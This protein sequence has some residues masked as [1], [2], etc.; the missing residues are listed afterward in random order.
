MPESSSLADALRKHFGFSEFRP[1][2]RELIEAVLAGRDVLGVLPTGGG[3]SLTYQLPALFLPGLTLVVSPLIALM[4]DQVDAFNRRHKAVAVAIHSNQT[5]RESGEAL[6]RV[7]RGAA[8][9]L[10]I[11]PERLELPG[12]R[13]QLA[14]L[15][16]RLLVIDEAHCVSMW[17]HDFRPS[18]LGLG[19]FAARLRP[20]PVLALTATA[21][22]A[23]RTDILARLGLVDPLVQVAPFDRPN[24]RFEVHPCDPGEKPR[25]LRRIIKDLA[26][27]GSQIVY[28]GRRKDAEEIAADLQEAGHRAVAYHAGLAAHERKA[29]QEAWLSG[30]ALIAVATIAFGMGIDKPDVRAVIHYQH[31]SSLESYYQEAGRA[32]RDGLP[33]QCTVLF[34][35]KDSALAQYFIRNRYPSRPQVLSL[36]AALPP[37]GIRP[38]DLKLLG[39]SAMSD[40]QRNVAL[41]TLLQQGLVSRDEAGNF[42]RGAGQPEQVSLRAMAARKDGDYRRLDAMVAYGSEATCHRAVVLRYFGETWPPDYRCRNCSAC[43]GGTADTGQAAAVDEAARIFLLNR[44]ALEAPGPLYKNALASFLGG[45]KSG[46]VPEQWRRLPGFGA[47]AH[48]RGETLRQVADEVLAKEPP[49]PAHPHLHSPAGADSSLPRAGTPVPPLHAA[50]MPAPQL[51]PPGA[52]SGVF[53]RSPKRSFTSQELETREVPRDRG[54]HILRLV[55]ANGGRFAPSMVV[56][57]LR[58]GAQNPDSRTP[59]LKALP[60][61]AVLSALPYG[62]LLPDVLAMWAKGYLCRAGDKGVK[63]CLTEKGKTVIH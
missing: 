2:Q 33:A 40:E 18:Y 54:L 44:E 28:V 14:A 63:L 42:H 8:A 26:G 49:S 16:P 29:A 47:L 55:A 34:S 30:R 22:P 23:T 48:L 27:Q 4:K 25:R 5:G 38:D 56:A 58:G 46:R 51:A 43:S 20:C 37:G 36:L 32:G 11:A 39:D 57:I 10:Y 9:L 13:T 7:H 19:A 45:S 35:A 31:P 61:W 15:K 3:K 41:V 52:E 50:K 59:E 62:Q 24:L 17:G 60:Q 6:A 1:G 21:T 53:W 12:F